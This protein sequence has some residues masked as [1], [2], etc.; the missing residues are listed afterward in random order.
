MNAVS[1]QNQNTTDEVF[2]ANFPVKTFQKG[3][4][5]NSVQA[6]CQVYNQTAEN[7]T[8]F[9]NQLVKDSAVSADITRDAFIRLYDK[10]EHCDSYNNIKAFLYV[11]ARNA[12]LNHLRHEQ[13]L[14]RQGTSPQ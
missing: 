4:T 14:R 3:R 11:S 7:L 12:S 1:G 5:K 13:N 6:L 8:H 10:R 9:S 2:A